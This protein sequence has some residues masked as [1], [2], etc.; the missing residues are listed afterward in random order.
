MLRCATCLLL[1][2]LPLLLA[3]CGGDDPARRPAGTAAVAGETPSTIPEATATTSPTPTPA[4][5]PA[6]PPSPQ[7]TPPSPPPATR[8]PPSTPTPIPRPPPST[9]TPIPR[10]PTAPAP[11]AITVR[12]RD[13]A[14][15]EASIRVSSGARVTAT[16]VNE[17]AGV[18]H[19]LTFSLPGLPHG[20]TCAGPCTATQVFTAGP[21]GTYYFL[22]TI[23][24][25]FGQFVVDP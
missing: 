10:P 19:N 25:M 23:H 7:A 16:L 5:A 1:P 9:P 21:P 17:D 2:A 6:S 15:A 20:D 22:C 3:G 18:E 8:P 12:A 11:V 13:L 14:F 4:P 24:S